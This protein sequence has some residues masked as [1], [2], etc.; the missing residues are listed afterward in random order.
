MAGD[1]PEY[2]AHVRGRR[3]CA[4]SS[5]FGSVEAHHAGARGLGQRA[6]DMTAIPL[7][8]LHH[9]DW[10]DCNGVFRGWSKEQR[11]AWAEA[12]IAETQANYSRSL[13]LPEWA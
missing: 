2:L 8:T 5:H 9:R 4:P 3:C 13:A 11:R 6:S 12:R 1:A 7:C 10:H